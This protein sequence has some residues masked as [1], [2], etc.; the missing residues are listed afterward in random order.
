MDE[1]QAQNEPQI[2]EQTPELPLEEE[3]VEE[4]VEEHKETTDDNKSLTEGPTKDDD[5]FPAHP[6][7]S[8][9]VNEETAE[10]TDEP[11]QDQVSKSSQEHEP[12][13]KDEQSDHETPKESKLSA[14]ISEMT[15]RESP[16]RGQKSFVT[17][18]L[19][20]DISTKYVYENL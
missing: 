10:A 17:T 20:E 16:M 15:P 2:A 19:A 1:E 5:A 18:S 6:S 7:T 3:A 13:V 9:T 8:E 12:P 14:R 4:A 11:V